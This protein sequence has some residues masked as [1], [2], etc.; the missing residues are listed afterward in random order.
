MWEGN[1]GSDIDTGDPWIFDAAVYYAH[2]EMELGIWAAERHKLR[3]KPYR[4]EYFKNIEPSEPKEEFDDR[5]RLYRCKTNFMFSAIY[6]GCP[7]RQEAFNDLVYLIDRYAP[8]DD[9]T[10]NDVKDTDQLDSL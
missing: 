1:I 7:S 10:K 5:I 3:A 6:P 8:R 2:N 4:V 9:G